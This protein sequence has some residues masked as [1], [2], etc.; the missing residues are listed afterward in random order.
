[1][2]PVGS[3]RAGLLR[4]ARC[5]SALS[6][7]ARSAGVY[8]PAVAVMPTCALAGAA[9]DCWLPLSRRWS[10]AAGDTASDAAAVEGAVGDWAGLLGGVWLS[11]AARSCSES[12]L[13]CAMSVHSTALRTNSR[14]CAST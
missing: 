7:S 5:S 2:A 8:C 3:G 11:R 12:L 14:T 9:A 4:S 6:T 10:G 1:M 13:C